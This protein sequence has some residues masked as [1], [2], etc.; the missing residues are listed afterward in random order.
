MKGSNLFKTEGIVEQSNAREVGCQVDI[1]ITMV[2]VDDKQTDSVL[3][4]VAVPVDDS[5][6]V[7]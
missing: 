3:Y 1:L 7:R 4:G 5:Y 6:S 2:V